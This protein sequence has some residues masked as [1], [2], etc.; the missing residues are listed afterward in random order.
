[1]TKTK[2]PNHFALLWLLFMQPITLHHHLKRCGIYP[3]ASALELWWAE[4]NR[5]IK[6]AYVKEMFALLLWVTPAVALLLS[7]IADAL[8][9]PLH[10]VGVAFGVTAGMAAGVTAGMAAGVAFGVTAGMTVGVAFGVAVGVADGVIAGVARVA[11]GVAFGVALGVALG[12]AAGVTVGVAVGVAELMKKLV[13]MIVIMGVMIGVILGFKE[14]VVIGIMTGMLVSISFTLSLY[15]IYTRLIPFYLIELLLQP[16]FYLAQRST[17]RSTLYF[18]PVLYHDLS[19]FPHPFLLSHILLNADTHPETVA[20]VLNACAIAPGQRKIGQAALAHLQARELTTLAQKHQFK[21]AVDLQGQWLSGIEGADNKLL[22]FRDT[23]RY[24]QAAFDTD[25]GYHRLQHLETTTKSLQALANQLRGD[26]SLLARVL[27]DTL[28]IWENVTASLCRDTQARATVIPNPFRFDNPL[29]PEND[30]P[31]FRGRENLIQR[32]A[33]LLAHPE[34]SASIALLGPRRCGKTSLL[35][36]LP[37]KVPDAVF[38]FFDIQDNPMDSPLAFFQAL[39]KRAREQAQRDRRLELPLILP[40]APPFSALTQWFDS[41]ETIGKTSGHRILLCLDE[42]E[43]LETSFPGTRNDLLK[44][45]GLFRA[46]IQHRSHVRLLVSGAAPFDELDNLWSDHLIN[47]QEL[48]IG[49][50]DRDNSLNLLRKP[51]PAF[52]DE[53]IPLTVA[54]AIFERVNGQPY[55]LQLY[56]KLLVDHL[57]ENEREQANI[58]DVEHI[59]NLVLSQARSYFSN[60]FSK[61]PNIQ[62]ALKNLAL[63]KPAQLDRR[64]HRWLKRRYLLNEQE[65]LSIPVFGRW[66]REGNR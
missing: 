23:A 63:S 16:F 37:A 59:E 26:D 36:M 58:Q 7:I 13:G 44:L 3:D 8:G 31:I 40:D 45:M 38:V 4:E 53:A 10:P 24:L 60:V 50:L 62:T 55:L 15:L 41:L 5:A 14:G 12:V 52:P 21:A 32:L 17:N 57:N 33:A 1:M 46:T 66:I 35:K 61:K 47:V 51:I 56:A 34:E 6:R 48:R 54:K 49:L 19:Y 25:N 20:R 2:L 65:Q 22:A 18:V 27:T 28:H 11:L 30:Q 9:Y 29:N 39:A 43:R 64:T 42:F